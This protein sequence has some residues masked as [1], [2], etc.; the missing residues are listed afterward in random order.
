M[1]K[2]NRLTFVKF[3]FHLECKNYNEYTTLEVI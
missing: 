1:K 3:H 2:V